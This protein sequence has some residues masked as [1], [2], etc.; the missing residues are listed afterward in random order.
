M[1][2]TYHLWIKTLYLQTTEYELF[3]IT[4][5]YHKS[6]GPCLKALDK[7]PMAKNFAATS[8][9]WAKLYRK[10]CQQNAKGYFNFNSKPLVAD[11]QSHG[12]PLWEDGGT[13]SISQNMAKWSNP[14]N[15]FPPTK[16]LFPP[17]IVL[18][19]LSSLSPIV[20]WNRASRSKQKG[21]WNFKQ[22]NESIYKGILQ[23]FWQVVLWY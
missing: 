20:T 19:I 8:I 23:I 22:Q 9:S 10:S 3:N 5:K 1:T 16:F 2:T 13:S 6:D 7:V 15:K 21:N 4:T 11:L 12:F 14:P 17:I 18:A